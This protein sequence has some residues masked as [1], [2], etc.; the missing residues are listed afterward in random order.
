M[1]ILNE[2]EKN[3]FELYDSNIIL[4]LSQCNYNFIL[5]RIK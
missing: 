2:L 5:N 3:S 1:N 4:N